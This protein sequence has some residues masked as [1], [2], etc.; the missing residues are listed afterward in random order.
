MNI[1]KRGF[2]I[3]ELVIAIVVISIAVGTLL[4]VLAAQSQSTIIPYITQVATGLAEQEMERITSLR[5]AQVINAGP[6]PFVFPFQDYTL[7]VV[8]SAVPVAIADDP[9]MTDYKQVQVIVANST[10]GSINLTTIVT[11]N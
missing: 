7:Q 10:I 8:V 3:I 2:T 9:G 4:T 5:F 1:K 6:T 11:N